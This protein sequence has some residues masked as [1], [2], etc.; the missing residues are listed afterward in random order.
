[1]TENPENRTENVSRSSKNAKHNRFDDKE[2]DAEAVA[3]E[4]TG[5]MNTARDMLS[6]PKQ[7]PPPGRWD[8]VGEPGEGLDE[9][10]GLFAADATGQE[11]LSERGD[12]PSPTARGSASPSA[13]TIT[14]SLWDQLLALEGQTIET[15]K[16][17]PFRVTSV[18]RTDRVTV[19]P[20]DGGSG[21]GRA[22][23]RARG[24]VASG[25]S[26]S[27]ARSA[28][29]DPAAR[30]GRGLGTPRVRRR[31]PARHNPR[32]DLRRAGDGLRPA[33]ACS[34]GRALGRTG[35]GSWRARRVPLRP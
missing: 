1:M 2:G 8:S 7:G 6:G 27:G 17:S 16:A 25:E 15:P 3:A 20:L 10:Q 31:S 30:G 28:R 34:R 23:P 11:Q 22:G 5:R 13:T 4:R 33:F 24:G 35:S 32:W 26:G 9:L 18:T 21:V 14:P 12:G 29:L 19:S